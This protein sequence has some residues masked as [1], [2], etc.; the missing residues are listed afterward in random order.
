MFVVDTCHSYTPSAPYA[1]GAYN[2]LKWEEN[3]TLSAYNLEAYYNSINVMINTVG[4]KSFVFN[5]IAFGYLILILFDFISQI[6]FW[7]LGQCFKY[8]TSQ[9]IIYLIMIQ[10]SIQGQRKSTRND[11]PDVL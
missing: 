11:G 7:T 1:C 4:C 6:K 2:I 10:N 8:P 5:L 3:K 9:N